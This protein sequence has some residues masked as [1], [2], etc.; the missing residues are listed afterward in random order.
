MKHFY[1]SSITLILC[2]G[3]FAST[4]ETITSSSSRKA[5]ANRSMTRGTCIVSDDFSSASDLWDFGVNYP[6]TMNGQV[7]NGRLEFWSSTANP[8][9]PDAFAIALSKDWTID[10]TQ[11]WAVSARWHINVPTPEYGDVGIAFLVAM[12][13]DYLNFYIERGYTIGGGTAN[14]DAPINYESTNLWYDGERYIQTEYDR[15]Y[16]DSTTYVW[17]IAAEQRIY[18]SDVL[19]APF[20][21]GVSVAGMSN[22]MDAS[23]GLAGYNIGLVPAFGQ[24]SLWVDDFCIID[25]HVIGID[26]PCLGDATDNGVVDVSD[27]LVV[28]DQWGSSSG[29][30]DVNDDGQVN[31]NDILVIV[32]EWGPCE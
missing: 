22:K 31:V 13:G 4:Q 28:I 2:I 9:Y 14:F 26:I 10:M 27:L 8:G 21:S 5:E 32:S 18:Y 23:L 7:T 3:T 15:N 17:Y 1:G 24:G 29:A 16:V 19:Y 6:N 30:G 12:E 11:D 20:D 25:G